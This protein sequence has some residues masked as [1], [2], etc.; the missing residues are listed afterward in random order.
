MLIAD[1]RKLGS[2]MLGCLAMAQITLLSRKVKL[3]VFM[4]KGKYR[5]SKTK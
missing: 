3:F 5:V 4:Q 1:R 2:E